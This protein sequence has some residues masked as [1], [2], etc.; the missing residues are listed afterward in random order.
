M[1][2]QWLCGLAIDHLQFSAVLVADI[3]NAVLEFDG[4]RGGLK[5]K[6]PDQLP[7]FVTDVDD[8]VFLHSAYLQSWERSSRFL[9]EV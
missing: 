9:I 7:V 2:R 5:A 4:Q 6:A 3:C 1:V 8:V